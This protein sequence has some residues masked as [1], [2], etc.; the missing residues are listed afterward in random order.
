M[1]KLKILIGYHLTPLDRKV[2]RQ[3]IEEN[4]PSLH[5][6]RK[7]YSINPTTKEKEIE[8]V[9]NSLCYKEYLYNVEEI[10]KDIQLYNVKVYENGRYSHYTVYMI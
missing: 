2:I 9:K 7:T 1:K 3:A 6:P 4:Q 8:W 5:T 10:D